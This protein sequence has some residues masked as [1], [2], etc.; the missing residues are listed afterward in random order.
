MPASWDVVAPVFQVYVNGAAPLA[1]TLIAPLHEP[2]HVGLDNVELAIFG[3]LA[4]TDADAPRFTLLPWVLPLAETVN[5]NKASEGALKEIVQAA[6]APPAREVGQPTGI[7]AGKMGT[8]LSPL[9]E[10]EYVMSVT[11]PAAGLLTVAV[12]TNSCPSA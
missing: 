4:E 5:V 11:D 10:V 6:D 12:N 8:A 2:A 3:L 7:G 9:R 1:T